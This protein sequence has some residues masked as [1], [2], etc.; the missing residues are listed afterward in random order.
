ME[1]KSSVQLGNEYF[2][3]FPLMLLFREELKQL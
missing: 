3:F 2:D 1:I